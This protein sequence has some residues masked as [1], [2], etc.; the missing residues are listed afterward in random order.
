MSTRRRA[1][2][3]RPAYPAGAWET[4]ESDVSTLRRQGLIVSA[5]HVAIV[6]G[7]WAFAQWKPR[8]RPQIVWFDGG[9]AGGGGAE[10]SSAA[11]PEPV[12]LAEPEPAP[13]IPP[14][15]TPEPPPPPEPVPV[16][17]PPAPPV[18]PVTPSE[19]P[20]AKPTPTPPPTTPKPTPRAT[21]T[22]SPTPKSTPKPT[23]KATPKPTPKATPKSTPK[24]S[25]PAA[26]P[27]A[28]ASP[29]ASPGAKKTDATG[30]AK[31]KS[32]AAGNSSKKD[33]G[34]GTGTGSAASGP[35]SGT[36]TAGKGKG[37]GP[38]SDFGWYFGSLRDRYMATWQ[39]P[40]SIVRSSAILLT[41]LKIRIGRDGS[42][43]H[44]EIVH[45]SGNPVM[46][47]SVVTAAERVKAVEPLPS[48][49]G[50]ETF[51]IAIDFKLDQD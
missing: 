11:E 6:L 23:P 41:T 27:S 24:A 37:S 26:S 47:D 44:H 14:P 1:K 42:I 3:I 32:P 8:E 19:L 9:L 38:A 28:K 10:S 15:P 4:A 36:G 34:E 46:D 30:A 12:P 13:P 29:K 51:E 21:P 50:A 17:P 45:A 18:E 25:T 7:L 40:T 5:V 49:L 20:V 39:Q 43:L 33:Q 2:P 31:N 16:E 22:P 48:G 35:G